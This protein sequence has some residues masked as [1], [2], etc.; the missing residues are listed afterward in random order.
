M[1]GDDERKRVAAHQRPH[2]AWILDSGTAAELAVGDGDAVGR[3]LAEDLQQ[4]AMLGADP[5]P[6][7]LELELLPLAAEVFG[8]LRGGI[9]RDLRRRRAAVGRGEA[10]FAGQPHP[11]DAVLGRLHAERP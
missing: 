11:P 3:R 8:E 7:E 5:G 2:V 1:A 9:P 10:A 6:I 4:M